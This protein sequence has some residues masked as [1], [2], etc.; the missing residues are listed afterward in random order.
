[1]S[2]VI[3]FLNFEVDA[4]TIP[5]ILVPRSIDLDPLY[6]SGD[7]NPMAENTEQ[8][9]WI[10]RIAENLKRI[11]RGLN[12]FV[13]ADLLW[14]PIEAHQVPEGEPRSQAPDIMV[15]FGR[16][17]GFRMSYKQWEEENIAPQVVFEILS[18]SNKTAQGK[19]KLQEKF[20][21]YQRYGV[22]E[23]YVY[24]PL[25]LKLE[26][27]L[28]EGEILKPVASSAL[29]SWV[30]PRMGIRMEWRS[31]Q[32]WQLFDLEGRPFMSFSELSERWEAEQIQTERERLRAIEAEEQAMRAQERAET[33][34]QRAE[35]EHQR[36]EAESQRAEAE[37]RQAQAERQRADEAEARLRLLE[38]ELRRS[39]GLE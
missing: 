28:R 1:M 25:A 37:A 8:Y 24:D 38:A 5:K 18:Q 34:R 39:Q 12:V 31:G 30:S 22:E 3:R 9:E 20:K 33:E 26:V 2:E 4:M 11:L 21:F 7:G 17:P 15:A 27:W 29:R 35:A 14:Y 13:G 23:Y 6:P 16:P 19:A 32:V 36:A 10:V